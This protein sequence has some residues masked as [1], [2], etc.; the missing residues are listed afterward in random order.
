MRDEDW[1]WFHQNPSSGLRDISINIFSTRGTNFHYENQKCLKSS[2]LV[3][4]CQTKNA[5]LWF[6]E[7]GIHIFTH[8]GK[9]K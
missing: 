2:F 7:Q 5:F 4:H 1:C 9:K 6:W 8:N 3:L